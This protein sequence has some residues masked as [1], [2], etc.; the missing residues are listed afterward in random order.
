LALI[1]IVLKFEEIIK[2]S[3]NTKWFYAALYK[4]YGGL[5][6]NNVIVFC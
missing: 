4:F 6:E 3:D 1:N 5:F 2:L